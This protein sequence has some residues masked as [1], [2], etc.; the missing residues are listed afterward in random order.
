VSSHR[1]DLVSLIGAVVFL[2]VGLVGVARSAG[3]IEHG[4]GL[5]AAIATLAGLGGVGTFTALRGL[6]ITE[7]T[8]ADDGLV[9]GE[10][11]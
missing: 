9:L 10:D 4:A 7:R 8:T 5:W 1:I 6:V 2:S 11:P 3:W